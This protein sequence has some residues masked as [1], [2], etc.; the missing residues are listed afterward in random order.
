M[1]IE[2]VDRTD[3]LTAEK[4]TMDS[5]DK[6]GTTV[7]N[8]RKYWKI[9]R[10]AGCKK[11]LADANRVSERRSDCEAARESGE[12]AVTEWSEAERKMEELENMFQ[13]LAKK[14]R[15]WEICGEVCVCETSRENADR[16]AN[17]QEFVG[18]MQESTSRSP[19][20]PVELDGSSK[21]NAVWESVIPKRTTWDLGE[22]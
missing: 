1:I 13:A 10:E 17:E 8:S 5:T 20:A 2:N 21:G 6:L 14:Q 15:N 7:S 4:K 3:K 18:A 12:P 9:Q 16:T 11:L 19:A 22:K